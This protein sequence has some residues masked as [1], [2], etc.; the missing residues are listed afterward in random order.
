MQTRR[1]E[2]T[3]RMLSSQTYGRIVLAVLL[4]AMLLSASAGV[5]HFGMDMRQGG[6]AVCPLMGAPAAVCN[7]NVFEH[8]AAWQRA[9]AGVFAGG[10]DMVLL[11]IA[12][13]FFLMFGG[14]HKL[15][16]RSD[17]SPSERSRRF[18]KDQI[19]IF[20]SLQEAFSNGIL[21]PKAF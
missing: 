12:L 11:L 6:M 15:A 20:N 7:M 13:A 1:A 18:L 8:I 19:D 4:L 2:Y 3:I 14:R 16:F 9:F 17:A 21:H 5:A 10:R